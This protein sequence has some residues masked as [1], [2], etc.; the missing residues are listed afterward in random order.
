MKGI[1]N[2]FAQH[3]A[4]Y[5]A[6]TLAVVILAALA[7]SQIV[8][9]SGDDDLADITTDKKGGWVYG[10]IEYLHDLRKPNEYFMEL[11]ASPGNPIPEVV[12]AFASTDSRV[13]VRLRGVSVP[14]EL[15]HSKDRNRP[16]DWLANER[17][18]WD[19][20]QRYVWN[21]VSPNKTFR[22][23]DLKV[24]DHAGDKVLEGD[25]EVFLGGQW[26]DLAIMMMADGH[27]RPIQKDGNDWDWGMETVPLLNPN[28]PK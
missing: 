15:Q 9:G 10:K 14:R 18:K 23:Y 1:L 11:R 5:P 21:I 19:K 24:V 28:V 20:A 6:C 26:F 13:I 22:V 27:A 17:R 12:G 25:M 7:V 3:W 16:H 8:V 4:F 2:R